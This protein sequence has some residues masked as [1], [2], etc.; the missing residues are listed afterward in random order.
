MW[1]D[2]VKELTNFGRGDVSTDL[3]V[4][5]VQVLTNK[6]GQLLGIGK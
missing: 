3:V 1:R 6:S 4:R 2:Y 5:P